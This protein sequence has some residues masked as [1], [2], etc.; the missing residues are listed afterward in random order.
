M[1]RDAVVLVVLVVSL[2]SVGLVMVYS[3]TGVTAERSPKYQD[4]G[5][6]LKRQLAW[7]A[8]SV[9]ALA[10]AALVP[11]SFWARW[12]LP[13]LAMS[14][15]LLCLV[16]VPG[17]GAEINAARRWIR[18]GGWFFQP[19][20]AAKLGIAVFVCGFAA[21]DPERIRRFFTGFMPPCAAVAAISG[22]ILVEPDVGTAVFIALVMGMTLLVAGIRPAH[23]LPVFASAVGFLLYYTMTHMD[24]V[25]RRMEAW[26]HPEKDPMGKG[27]QII[28]SLQ[29]LGVGGWT[30]VG[31]GRGLSKLYYLPEVHSDFILPVIGE[32]LGF[33]GAA[34][35]LALYAALAVAGYRVTFRARDRF[36]FLLSFAVTSYIILQATINAAVVTAAIP[37]KGIP[38]PFVSA[39][40]SSLVCAM[41]GVG[42]LVRV[43]NESERGPCGE[44]VTG[45]CLPGEAREAIS[46]PA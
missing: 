10:G 28:Q 16:F 3:A 46:S 37:T 35:V 6:F 19:S 38:M 32:E 42:M 41:A 34:G 12:R 21:A 1:S 36:G 14:A 30:G 9:A 2:V 24:H 4:A 18:V 8:I 7:S 40:G 5:H 23:A 45:S 20:E 22:L 39:G 43:A 29:A 31:L 11:L 44:G 26:L 25:G 27:H 33:L 15:A 13:V 17:V